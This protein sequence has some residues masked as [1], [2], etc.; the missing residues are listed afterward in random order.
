MYTC[1]RTMFYTIVVMSLFSELR[2][3][4]PR[5]VVGGLD[6]SG[7]EGPRNCSEYNVH[8]AVVYCER[9]PACVLTVVHFSK[10][11]K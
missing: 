6:R 10:K 1:A 9:V 4:V 8:T 5:S 3:C 7:R 2:S 11:T